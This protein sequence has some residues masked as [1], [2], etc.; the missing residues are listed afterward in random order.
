VDG[1]LRVSTGVRLLAPLGGA[2]GGGQ[3][4]GAS[5][6]GESFGALHP[7]GGSA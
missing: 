4:A 7:G 3:D 1:H 2:R 6:G 5:L